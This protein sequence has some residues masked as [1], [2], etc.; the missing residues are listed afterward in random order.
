MK[1]NE[2]NLYP[3]LFGLLNFLLW[4]IIYNI[5]ITVPI[6]GRDNYFISVNRHIEQE[7]KRRVNNN[8]I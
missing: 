5:D 8:L 4:R 1:T 7:E 6:L 3:G 2:Q